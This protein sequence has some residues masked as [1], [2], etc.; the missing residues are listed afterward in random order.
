MNITAQNTFTPAVLIQGGDAFDV[1]VSGTFVAT[2]TLQRSKDNV[3]WR[4]V[5]SFT[6]PAQKSGLAGTAWYH[7]VGIKTGDFTS[8]TAVVDIFN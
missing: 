7:R 4:D 8:G 2:V 6:A 1:T 5:E 3:T